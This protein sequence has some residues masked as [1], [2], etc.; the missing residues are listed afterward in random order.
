MRIK[1]VFLSLALA[2]AAWAADVAGRWKSSVDTPN[3]SMDIVFAF[4]ANGDRMTG[5]ATGPAGEV[6]ITDIKI[7]GNQIAFTVDA[8]QFKI[9]HTGTISGD[10]IEVRYG[11]R[12][13]FGYVGQ[14]N[15]TVTGTAESQSQAVNLPPHQ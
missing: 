2:V 13:N 6:A 10:E 15:Q 14:A 12:A 3:G 4:K 11:R 5:T 1:M 9:L 8:G 7:D